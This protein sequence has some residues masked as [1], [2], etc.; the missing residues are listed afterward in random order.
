VRRY[1]DGHVLGN[2]CAVHVRDLEVHSAE[3]SAVG[4]APPGDVLFVIM[5][6]KSKPARLLI[7][8]HVATN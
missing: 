4:G 5:Q 7:L 3:P 6:K 1:K 2:L 8:D